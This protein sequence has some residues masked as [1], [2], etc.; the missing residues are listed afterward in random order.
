MINSGVDWSKDTGDP[1]K[2]RHHSNVVAI[3]HSCRGDLETLDA[4]LSSAR[5]DRG[6]P[7][8]FSFRYSSSETVRTEFVRAMSSMPIAVRVSLRRKLAGPREI[9]AAKL[10]SDWLIALHSASRGRLFVSMLAS[11]NCHSTTPLSCKNVSGDC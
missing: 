2:R 7:G 1:S 4:V 3:A 5:Q 11:I 10:R 9:S 6:L 8:S